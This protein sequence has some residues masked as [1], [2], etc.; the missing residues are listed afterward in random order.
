MI[1][2]ILKGGRRGIMKYIPLKD[3]FDNRLVGI[4]NVSPESM[5]DLLSDVERDL[6]DLFIFASDGMSVTYYYKTSLFGSD[7]TLWTP[8]KIHIRNFGFVNKE[9]RSW[10]T[11]E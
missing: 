2:I 1:Q 7:M 6:G 4:K 3:F 11:E 8:F 10:E 5:N 9:V